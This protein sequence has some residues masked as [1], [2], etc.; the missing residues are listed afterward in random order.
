MK[1]AFLHNLPVEYYP[2]ATNMIGLANKVSNIQLAVFTTE[3]TKGLEPFHFGDV[4]I[5]RTTQASPHSPAPWRLVRAMWWHLKTALQ[6]KWWRPDVVIYMEPHSAIAAFLYL[7]LARRGHA[8]LFIHHHE[9]YAPEDYNRVGMR[10]AA[11][12]AKLEGKDLF[13][14]AEW[15][16]QTNADRV[17]LQQQHYQEVPVEKWRVLPN[18]PPE[19]WTEEISRIPS[20]L[21]HRPLRLIYLG[22]A[23]FEDTYIREV[24]EWVARNPRTLTLSICGYNVSSDVWE[25]LRE[26][27]DKNIA[28]DPSGV[29]YGDIPA[30]LQDFDIGLV[31]YKGNTSNFIHNIPNKVYEYMRC[32]L[33]VLY[34]SEMTSIAHSDWGKGGPRMVEFKLLETLNPEQL[35]ENWGAYEGISAFST[36]AALAPLLKSWNK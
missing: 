3:N 13:Q 18:Y 8:R 20:D 6:L 5:N 27:N 2:P 19:A 36:E 31:L 23:S 21:K 10:M 4:T 34:P 30:Y 7:R 33:K 25:W 32:G 35:V 1:V 15:I 14:R 24:V 9:Y 16:S 29:R 26:R 22:S 17:A 12:G 28:I 11:L